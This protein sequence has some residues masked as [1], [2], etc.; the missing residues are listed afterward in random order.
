[1]LYTLTRGVHSGDRV[2]FRWVSFSSVISDRLFFGCVLRRVTL[3]SDRL[4]TVRLKI[5]YLSYR[6]SISSVLV[7]V[8]V[9]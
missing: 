7:E 2:G 3:G 6:V 4:V 5:G 8:R 1:M 9:K